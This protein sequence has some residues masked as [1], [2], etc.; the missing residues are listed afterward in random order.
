MDFENERNYEEKPAKDQ[1]TGSREGYQQQ[2]GNGFQRDYRGRSPRPR[3]HT[4]QRPAYLPAPT[5][6]VTIASPPMR[7]DS[8]LRASAQVCS[9]ARP[10]REATAPVATTAKTVVTSPVS[11]A[12]DSVPTSLTNLTSLTRNLTVIPLTLTSRATSLV[13]LRVNT[14]SSRVVATVPTTITAVTVLI[15]PVPASLPMASPTASPLMVRSR[16][17]SV[18]APQ[19][20]TPMRSTA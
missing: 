9:Q 8:V 4:G 16:I 18:P 3:I 2:S 7:A 13:S 6:P 20:T 19:T 11:R 14:V 1:N 12:M 5:V 17:T 15:R 10:I